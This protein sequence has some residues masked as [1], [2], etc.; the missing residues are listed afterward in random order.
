MESCSC[1][2]R[3][4]QKY[5]LDTD[6]Y[7]KLRLELT[8]YMKPDQYGI[9]RIS[10]IYFD[11]PD[12][13]L[14][15][16]SLEKPAYKEKLRLRCYGLPGPQDPVYVEVKKKYKGIVYKRRVEMPLREAEAY[17]YHGCRPARD[18]Q[19]LREVDYMRQFYR[20]LV[21]AAYI[22][23]ER[24]ALYGLEHASLRVTFDWNLTWR[25]QDLHL[26][27][28]TDGRLLLPEDQ[29]LMEIKLPDV[30]PMWMA[31]LLSSLQVFPTSFSKYGTAYQ[32]SACTG[33]IPVSPQA[34]AQKKGQIIC[35][36]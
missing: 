2:Q 17:L 1:F 26:D 10:S 31:R 9:N 29:W 25:D 27:G 11:T 15:R 14:I 7:Q 20:E 5:L 23:Y 13:R 6:T 3:F 32:T 33:K 24:V 35:A 34:N 8:P 12:H 21:P 19:V 28:G 18:T 4:E 16:S 36:S 22:G 30:I